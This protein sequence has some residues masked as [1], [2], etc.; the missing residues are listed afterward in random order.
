MTFNVKLDI[1][2]NIKVDKEGD[3]G[4]GHGSRNIVELNTCHFRSLFQAVALS[5]AEQGSVMSMAPKQMILIFSLKV[6]I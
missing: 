4:G 5:F 3:M 6:C 2:L 1:K